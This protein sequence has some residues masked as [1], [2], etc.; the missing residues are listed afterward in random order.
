MNV[1]EPA[2]VGQYPGV[3]HLQIKALAVDGQSFDLKM[4]Y[5]WILAHKSRFFYI[6]C[7]DAK[8]YLKGIRAEMTVIKAAGGMVRNDDGNYL[9]IFRNGKW[10]LPK[11]K[12]E[13]DEKVD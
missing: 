13:K 6:H 9:F 7:G 11:G 10:D 8:A 12:V 3:D 4:I 5:T 1:K 2:F